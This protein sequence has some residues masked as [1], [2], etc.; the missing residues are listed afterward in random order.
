M[1]PEDKFQ[2]DLSY[3]LNKLKEQ[4]LYVPKDY[5]IPYK[6]YTTV[7]DMTGA[8]PLV[9]DEVMI[10][11]KLAEMG[12]IKDFDFTVDHNNTPTLQLELLQPKFDEVYDNQKKFLN[13]SVNDSS[14]VFDN[15]KSRIIWRGD[16]CE[17][18]PATNQFYLCEKMFSVPFGTKVKEIEFLD[19]LGW[20]EETQRAVYDAMRLVNDRIKKA[21]GISGFFVWRNNLVYVNEKVLK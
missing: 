13:K 7:I 3:V 8:T 19:N 1:T 14:P 6:L 2:K 16:E 21:F 20:K 10:L 12:A 11:A 9:E 15:S 17:I 18:P 5:R 4:S